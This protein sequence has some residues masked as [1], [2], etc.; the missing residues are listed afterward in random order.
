MKESLLIN[1][2]KNH[3]MDIV[4]YA[5][6]SMKFTDQTYLIHKAALYGH[7]DLLTFLIHNQKT[8][9]LNLKGGKYGS[10]PLFFSI[11]NQQHIV[12]YYIWKIAQEENL[13]LLL[14]NNL[15][16]SILHL[17]IKLDNI[18]GFIILISNGCSLDLVDN[19]NR[20]VYEYAIKSGKYRFI[21]FIKR[22][23][24]ESGKNMNKKCVLNRN[25]VHDKLCKIDFKTTNKSRKLKKQNKH[26]FLNDNSELLAENKE[27]TT[28]QTKS[29]NNKF[30]TAY[31]K[32]NVTK[33]KTKNIYFEHRKKSVIK[34][35]TPLKIIEKIDTDK[36]NVD[37]YKFFILVFNLF[38]L[39]IAPISLY[40]SIP[41]AFMKQ[42]KLIRSNFYILTNMIYTL[43]YITKLLTSSSKII[44]P[45]ILSI[46]NIV[47]L[48]KLNITKP[49]KIKKNTLTNL[50][51]IIKTAITSESCYTSNIETLYK[52]QRICYI[53][54]NF[55][56]E[57]TIHC[58]LCQGCIQYHDHHCKFL[59]VC[60]YK[61]NELF[62]DLYLLTLV[63]LLF[64]LKGLNFNRHVAFFYSCVTLF[65]VV[66][67]VSRIATNID[68][69][70]KLRSVKVKKNS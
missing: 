30:P 24:E 49:V 66:Q 51:K 68:K 40:L 62:F 22:Y 65:I 35:F 70:S 54:W 5:D 37:I 45:G 10:T 50:Q 4:L 47:F 34:N 60:V 21:T 6:L 1:A 25:I 17:C 63:S 13:D 2:L 16:L 43:F 42:K 28:K 31:H 15:G 27:N 32:I 52:I 44:V 39:Y 20:N 38:G 48:M 9:I 7:I 36:I 64:Y 55:K 56:D 41:L 29:A 12:T 3:E 61:R 57:T 18:I 59:N 26:I 23:L 67:V 58:H 46:L 14:Y 8:S 69:I 33:N 11:Y 53:C 19:K